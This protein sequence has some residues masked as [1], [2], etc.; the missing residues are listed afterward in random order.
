M[1]SA[2]KNVTPV[3]DGA[4]FDHAEKKCTRIATNAGKKKRPKCFKNHETN[5][6]K[7]PKMS[8]K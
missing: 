6:T 7:F 8:W 4:R 3:E 2:H 5:W 1:T